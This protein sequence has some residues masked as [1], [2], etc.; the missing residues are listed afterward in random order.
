M[1]QLIKKRATFILKSATTHAPHKKHL[2][3]ICT[4]IDRDERYLI[5]PVCTKTNRQHNE[6]CIITAGE[7]KFI[8][9]ESYI[10]YQH[11]KI[12]PASFLRDGIRHEDIN[13][14]LFLRIC[15]GIEKSKR[16]ARIYKKYYLKNKDNQ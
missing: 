10:A 3:V 9:H 12:E 6:Y 1:T 15:N 8:R 7:H 2:F 5:I 13:G 4:N 16:M 14:Q 11:A